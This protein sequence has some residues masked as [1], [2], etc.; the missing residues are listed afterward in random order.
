MVYIYIYIYICYCSEASLAHLQN[1]AS[2]KDKKN[3]VHGIVAFTLVCNRYSFV[4]SAFGLASKYTCKI[5]L[6]NG[7]KSKV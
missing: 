5:V 4:T 1:A 6:E 3:C 7:I 2:E